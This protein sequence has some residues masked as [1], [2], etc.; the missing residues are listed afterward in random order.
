M[1]ACGVAGLFVAGCVEIRM[2]DP[3]VRYIAF[4]DSATADETTNGYPEILMMLLGEPPDT[5]ASEGESGETSEEGL[6]RLELLLADGVYPDANVLLY[7]EG[8]NDITEFISEHD[9]FRL[10]SPNAPDDP[11]A[12]ELAQQLDES[13][14]DIESAI[15]AAHRK[16]LSVFV[17]TYYFMRESIG[18]CDAL[19]LNLLLPSQAVNANTYV[20]RLNERI[21]TAAANQGAVLVDVASED[22]RIRAD[23]DNYADCNHLSGQGNTIVADLFFDAIT[24]S[25]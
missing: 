15:A 24:A 9:S 1:V 5:F 21:R 18:I 20:V 14:A 16:G 2:P 11:L 13:Q 23:P 3:A 19:P 10:Y 4:G 6:V 17:A 12:D 8:G 25:W 7:W 22:D